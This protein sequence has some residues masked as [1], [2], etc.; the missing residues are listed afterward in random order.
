MH[1]RLVRVSV[2]VALA[3]TIGLGALG[4]VASASAAKPTTTKAQTSKATGK[5]TGKATHVSPAE[6]RTAAARRA[7]LA[8]VARDDAYL[9]R[10]LTRSALRTL[11]A[12]ARTILESSVGQDR[13][14]LAGYATTA[15]AAGT[16][17][18]VREV[19]ALVRAL[20]PEVYSIALGQLQDLAELAASAAATDLAVSD[21]ATVVA[22]RSAAGE[23]LSLLEAELTSA[24]D[25]LAELAAA[26][27]V[28]REAALLLTGTTPRIEVQ[29]VTDEVLRLAALLESADGIV[30]GVAE[31][32]AA[33]AEPTEEPA[34]E[35]TPE[36]VQEPAPAA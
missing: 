21:L 24:R 18:E 7:V 4:P 1:T 31:A 10:V 13:T 11:D 27:P 9:A 22:E 36:P 35:S 28:A 23:D 12:D 29:L 14:L 2:T 19:A 33:P 32:L 34:P 15:R 3:A 25:L 8:E 26:A 17:A 20:R 6:R 5:A 30:A 16:L